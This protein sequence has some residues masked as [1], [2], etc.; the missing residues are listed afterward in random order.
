MTSILDLWDY[1]RDTIQMLTDE[2]IQ[3]Q[4]NTV[5]LK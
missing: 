2:E 5:E 3:E 4:I 1:D